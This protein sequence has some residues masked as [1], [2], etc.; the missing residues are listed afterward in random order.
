M[1]KRTRS[2]TSRKR[3]SAAERARILAEAKANGWTADQIAK[4]YGLSKWTV[5][6][7]R[8]G[9]AKVDGATAGP[10]SDSEKKSRRTR[11]TRGS[12]R[13]SSLTEMLRP[14][15]AEMVREELARLARL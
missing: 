2:A 11:R 1:A 15:I 13:A 3:L 6:G 12:Q 4:K 5:Y 8:Q 14:L 10:L 7:W 9:R